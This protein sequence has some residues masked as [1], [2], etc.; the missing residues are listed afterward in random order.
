MKAAIYNPYLDTLGG[1]ERY[2]VCFGLALSKMGYDVDLYWVDTSIKKSIEDRFGLSLKKINIVEDIKRGSGYDLCF[3]V[4]D[5]SI[6]LMHARNN[7]IHFQ[8]P[9]KDV[10]GKSLINRMKLFRVKKIICNSYFTKKVIDKEYGVNSVVLYPPVSVN[11]FKPAK[12]KENIILS[13][14]RFSQLAQAKRQD[15]LISAF[16]RLYKSHEKCKDFKLVLVGGADVGAS[17]YV[18]K[19]MHLSS[20]LPVEIH[21]SVDYQMLRNY[22]AKAKIFWSAS[23]FGVD[24]VKSPQKVEHFGISL[25]EAMASGI[26]IFAYDA[27]GHKEII[28][29]EVNGFL[30]NSQS[31]LIRKTCDLIL[32]FDRSKEIVK[33]AIK[34]SKD[35]SL[36]VFFNEVSNI[37]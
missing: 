7:F 18:K 20:G 32:D 2:S 5:G 10:D 22:Y 27:G 13:V 6:P 9:F 30:W 28:E 8:I 31:E 12:R 4:S 1:G 14:G 21:T 36:G 19:L 34:R 23:G 24:E 37:I 11:D 15:V 29:N 17:E 35:F 25:V 26:V 33:N 16:R 3:W